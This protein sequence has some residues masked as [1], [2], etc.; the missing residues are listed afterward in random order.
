MT[1]KTI[2]NINTVLKK[3]AM[4]KAKKDGITL[5]A[6]LNFSVRAYV[7]DRIKINAFEAAFEKGRADIK[8]GNVISQEKLLRELG[9]N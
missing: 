5:S 6:V 3:A 2:F 1:T 9:F 7:E 8:A 4:K